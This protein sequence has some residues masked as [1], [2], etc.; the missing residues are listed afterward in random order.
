MKQPK[1]GSGGE[2]LIWHPDAQRV[3]AVCL[4]SL[5]A[6]SDRGA[7]TIGLDLIDTELQGLLQALAPSS[8][9]TQETV[10]LFEYPG[11]L[12]SVAAKSSIAHGARLINRSLLDAI[13][14]MRKLRNLVAHS[15]NT[16]RL[17]NHRT[18]LRAICQLGPD[19]PAGINRIAC[20]TLVRLTVD[21][22]QGVRVNIDGEEI[23]PMA[24]SEAALDWLH[25]HQESL[26][27]LEQRLPR[28]EL[29][30]GVGMICALLIIRREEI[31][32]YVQGDQ[33]LGTK[34]L[35]ARPAARSK[36]A[37]RRNR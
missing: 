4:D 14:S 27:I 15:S 29:G 23:T 18:A 12:S 7:V 35:V 2:S 11:P 31:S 16:F 10:R 24:S 34:L 37:M 17:A 6:E 21:R 13:S 19:V 26:D 1:R 20:E 5:V 9:S 8:L 22:L 33:L 30:L 32:T 36:R 28:Y 3:L 25:S